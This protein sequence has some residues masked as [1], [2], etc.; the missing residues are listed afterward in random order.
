MHSCMAYL[1]SFYADGRAI[2]TS[3]CDMILEDAIQFAR[4][5]LVSCGADCFYL[6]DES[7]IDIWHEGRWPGREPRL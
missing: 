1:I 6:A 7:G 2:E 3:T 4:A 5:G